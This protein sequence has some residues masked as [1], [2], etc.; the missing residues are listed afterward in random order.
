MLNPATFPL[1]ARNENLNLLCTYKRVVAELTAESAKLTES[2]S[3]LLRERLD[4]ETRA[5]GDFILP[6]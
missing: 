4:A 5:K 6:S 2:V 1:V 3:L